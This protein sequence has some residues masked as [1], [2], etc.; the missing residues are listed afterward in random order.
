MLIPR[1][2]SSH[3]T[4]LGGHRRSAALPTDEPRRLRLGYHADS[5]DGAKL[6]GFS[7][8]ICGQLS[9]VSYLSG[10]DKLI[11]DHHVTDWWYIQVGAPAAD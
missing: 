9:A 3:R 7:P 11:F 6:F 1:L 4:Q 2:A 5:Y 10:W 8:Y